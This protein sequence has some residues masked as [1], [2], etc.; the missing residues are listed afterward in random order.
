MF[1]SDTIVKLD[2]LIFQLLR[3]L[4]ERFR[5]AFKYSVKTVEHHGHL[6][7]NLSVCDRIP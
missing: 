6:M 5:H 4:F 7:C 3:V 1:T 2:I